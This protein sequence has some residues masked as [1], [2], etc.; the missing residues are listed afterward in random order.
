[1]ERNSEENRIRELFVELRKQENVR[2]P[3]FDT[4]WAGATTAAKR[5]RHQHVARLMT[6]G[7]IIAVLGTILA[8]VVIRD[9]A[10]NI[11]SLSRSPSTVASQS[12]LDLP[13]KTR[14]LICEWRSPTDFLLQS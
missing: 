13:W 3:D 7:A 9:R 10:Q 6:A 8:V 5:E 12:S 14:V 1:M 11:P 2:V 4:V